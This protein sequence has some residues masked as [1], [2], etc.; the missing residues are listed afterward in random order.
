MGHDA[1]SGIGKGAR[2]ILGADPAMRRAWLTR[3][4]GHTF[5][6]VADTAFAPEETR[7]RIENL[8]GA[9]QVPLGIAGP[10]R[11]NGQ[12]ADGLFFVPFATT[13]GTLVTTY[14]YGMRAITE[15]G[16]ANARVVAD[17][18][19]I[20][21][22]FVVAT[23]G[24]ALALAN[25]LNDHL[26]ELQAVAAETTDHGRLVEIRAHVFGRRVFAR[27][28]FSTGDAMGLNMVNL[29]VDHVCRHVTEA[30]PCERYYLRCNYSSDK[31]PAAINL[32]R[33]YGKEVAVD[34][35]LPAG[36]MEAHLGVSTRELLEFAATGRLGTM[37]AGALGANAHFANGLAAIFLACGQDVAQIVNASIGFMDFELV[38]E[39]DLYVAAR[40][41][42]LVVGTVGGGTSLPTQSE[43]LAL[44]G[45]SGD[46][47]ARKFAEIVGASL[48]AGEL[49]IC[50]ALA[51]GRFIEAHR[52][53]RLSG[54][55][56][57][58]RTAGRS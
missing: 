39:S 42:N 10:I 43:S 7:G 24:D 26:P 41:P 14:Q 57:S 3:N 6:A 38:N 30:M 31:K 45:C 28:V 29:A 52:Q 53:S 23:T 58:Q 12:D 55:P 50:A 15:A 25:W 5:E 46:G 13:E 27:F 47:T 17:A 11:V 19:D 20:T 40:L 1:D 4:A 32:F 56:S 35:T 54:R 34:L 49:A 21:P 8:I 48:V 51:N 36:V 44:L 22:C 16:G 33:P 37:Q 18:L 9:T 2:Q